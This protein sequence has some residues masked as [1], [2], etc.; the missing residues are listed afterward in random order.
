METPGSSIFVLHLVVRDKILQRLISGHSHIQCISRSSSP[1]AHGISNQENKY[2]QNDC[3]QGIFSAILPGRNF[4]LSEANNVE[5]SPFYL[6]LL[7]VIF[8]AANYEALFVALC[9]CHE[10]QEECGSAHF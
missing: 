10:F 7:T 5:D 2:F 4:A 6:F 8:Y 3:N 9:A 1:G